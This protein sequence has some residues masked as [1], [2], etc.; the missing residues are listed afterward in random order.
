[1]T[2]D[3]IGKGVGR[4]DHVDVNKSC[5]SPRKPREKDYFYSRGVKQHVFFSIKERHTALPPCLKCAVWARTDASGANDLSRV[6]KR[7]GK[8]RSADGSAGFRTGRNFLIDF[9]LT[10]L[11]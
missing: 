3:R 6:P 1:M 4:E 8:K 11:E 9:G 7:K 2:I 5:R 10:S